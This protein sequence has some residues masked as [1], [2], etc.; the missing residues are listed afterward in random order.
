MVNG[1]QDYPSLYGSS[2]KIQVAELGNL[3]GIPGSKEEC[4]FCR[5]VAT[6]RPQSHFLLRSVVTGP[7]KLSC[8]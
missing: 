2:A 6:S 4:N 5:C 8:C 7:A 3:V 1:L